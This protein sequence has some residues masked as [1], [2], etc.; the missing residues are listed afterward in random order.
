MGRRCVD[1]QRVETGVLAVVRDRFETGLT[2]AAALTH[3]PWLR[4]ALTAATPTLA[5]WIETRRA[6]FVSAIR[7]HQAMP[8]D[9]WEDALSGG[10]SSARTASPSRSRYATT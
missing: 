9:T 1:P 3:A 5:P 8:A 2:D 7:A 10:S 6:R 4:S